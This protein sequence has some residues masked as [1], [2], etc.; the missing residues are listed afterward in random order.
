MSATPARWAALDTLRAVRGGEL[1]DRALART[2]ER[3][4]VRDRPWVQ[5]L[6]YG[7]FRLRGRIDWMLDRLV[8]RG[9]A[10]LEPDVLDI[11]RLGAYQ[12]LEMGSVPAYAAVSQ[13]VEMAKRVAGKGGGGLVNGVLQS[14]RRRRDAL[15][16]PAF[17]RDPVGHLSEWGS[18][19]RW[20][21]ERWVDRFGAEGARRLVEANNAR[22]E[23]YIRAVCTTADDAR[24]RLEAAG[25]ESEPVPFAPDALR[26]VPPA[27]AREALA[28]VPSV[29]QDPAA[30]SVVRYAAVPEGARVADLCAAPGGK[31]VALAERARSVVAADVSFA[32]MARVRENAG[33]IGGLSVHGLVADARW[34]AV[35]EADVVLVD[36]PCTGTGTLRRHPD[37]KWRLA[38][39]DLSALA[40]LQ[41]EILD[42]AAEVVRPGGLLIYSTCSLEP[43]EN[44]GQVDAFL[45]RHP[46]FVPAPPP[47]GTIAAEL[48]DAAGR[49][50]VLPQ[51]TGVDGA[52]AS[53]LR[54]EN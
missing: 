43:E 51:A 27:G 30:G 7:T 16:F 40:E 12:L 41:R 52:F 42:A 47:A 39:T 6:V 49:L 22:P 13:A 50:V 3:V 17:G 45:E 11:L 35:R 34:P 31:A 21:V 25:I 15:E 4:A 53:R 29:V 23:L 48:L 1:A 5:E 26:I 18:H 9:I 37:G 36:V 44:E 19:P 20:L 46:E 10:S 14:L 54:R 33:R 32:R 38:P 24:A 2:L 28:V 8:R